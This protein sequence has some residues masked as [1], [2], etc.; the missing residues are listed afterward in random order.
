MVTFR[1]LG[2]GAADATTE[3][4]TGDPAARNSIDDPD[5]ITPRGG[6]LSGA[7]GNFEYDVPAH[8][9]TV[10]TIESPTST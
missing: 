5:R 10:I 2:S 9:V 8:S 1:L 4:L 6:Y 7:D 3:V